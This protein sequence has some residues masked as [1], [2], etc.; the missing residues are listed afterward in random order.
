[1][2]PKILPLKRSAA[3]AIKRGAVAP[4]PM[5]KKDSKGVHEN[6]VPEG[7][8]QKEREDTHKEAQHP[9][10]VCLFAADV[11]GDP[12]PENAKDGSADAGEGENEG[13]GHGVYAFVHH[14]PDIVHH[15]DVNPDEREKNGNATSAQKE[16]VR[17][18]SFRVQSFC[19]LV[20]A[21]G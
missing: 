14:E 19:R 18:T 16:R 15:H 13:G 2:R 12:S 9:G 1:M 7:I 21:A 4:Q 6:P 17:S 11:I 5:P 8:H 20:D 10:C 3:V